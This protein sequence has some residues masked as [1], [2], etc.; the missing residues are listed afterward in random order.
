MRLDHNRVAAR[1]V[2]VVLCK[3]LRILPAIHSAYPTGSGFGSSRFSSATGSFRTL[4]ASDSF[5]AVF[6]EAVVRDRFIGRRRRYLYKPTL[7]QLA[8]TEITTIADLA[9]LDFT[10]AAAYELGADTDAK[11]AR[12]HLAGQEFAEA[13]HNSTDLDGILFDSRLTGHRCVAIFDRAQ[14]KLSGSPPADLLALA[15]AYQEMRRLGITVRA[16]RNVS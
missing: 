13:L 5:A 2:E 11:G 1:R 7:E 9:L 6:A 10:G 16:K 8:V 14:S 3:W 15:E 12:A 4:Y